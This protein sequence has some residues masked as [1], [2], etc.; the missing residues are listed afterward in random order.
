MVASS[1]LR[2]QLFQ[3]SGCHFNKRVL[4]KSTKRPSINFMMDT[5]SQGILAV[6]MSMSMNF[7]FFLLNLHSQV[8][9]N[10]IYQPF[11]LQG[12]GGKE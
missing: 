7:Q 6:K 4:P 1:L 10:T 3:T 11:G 8:S 9:R 12:N 5:N 2:L